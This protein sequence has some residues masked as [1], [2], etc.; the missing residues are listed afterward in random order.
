MDEYEQKPIAQAEPDQAALH[1]QVVADT[2]KALTVTMRAVQGMMENM[3]E[4]RHEQRAITQQ[5]IAES[6]QTREELR[7]NRELQVKLLEAL[8]VGPRPPPQP[9]QA[10]SACR[11]RFQ[12]CRL[13]RPSLCSRL[14][15]RFSGLPSRTAV[16][17]RCEGSLHAALRSPTGTCS[18]APPPPSPAPQ[19]RQ[20]PAQPAPSQ[21]DN[22]QGAAGH[23]PAPAASGGAM[24]APA[25]GG[26]AAAAGGAA[27][28]AGDAAAEED[29]AA[30][31]LPGEGIVKYR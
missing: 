20:A 19:A 8:Q 31:V 7:Q 9:P 15:G 6:Q 14:P 28:A 24:H 21:A 27:A 12:R 23:M 3:Q 18:P 11:L 17:C 26:A 22:A 2:T 29:G 30:V 1:L 5:L 13:V 10:V 16:C 25:A 4:E